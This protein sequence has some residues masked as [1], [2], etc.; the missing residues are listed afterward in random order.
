MSLAHLQALTGDRV[1]F[2]RTY[3]ETHH[4]IRSER[5]RFK[6]IRWDGVLLGGTSRRE[7]AE[8]LAEVLS[9]GQRK[10]FVEVRP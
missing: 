7:R 8:Q 2:R 1:R 6:L 10:G 3:S 4:S 5:A 9:Q